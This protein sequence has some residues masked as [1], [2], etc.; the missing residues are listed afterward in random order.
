MAAP[1]YLRECLKPDQPSHECWPTRASLVQ[2]DNL[3][4]KVHS[5]VSRSHLLAPRRTRCARGVLRY[6]QIVE[7]TIENT[8]SS[9]L[10]SMLMTRLTA[11]PGRPN[12][13]RALIVDHRGSRFLGEPPLCCMS[14]ICSCTFILSTVSHNEGHDEPYLVPP[15]GISENC[16][17]PGTIA[18]THLIDRFDFRL[19]V[20]HRKSPRP[21]SYQ[22]H[23][24]APTNL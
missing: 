12:H 15:S 2:Y 7:P 19:F 5:R 18:K 16:P 22:T 13:A 14:H 1:I 11:F 9:P 10:A 23:A 17:C 6:A 20:Y 8:F 3:Y 4:P 21:G 24:S